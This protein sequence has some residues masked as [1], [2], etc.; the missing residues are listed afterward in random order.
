M[1]RAFARG[2]A[3]VLLALS[4]AATG[5]GPSTAL[6]AHHVPTEGLQPGLPVQLTRIKV[7]PSAPRPHEMLHVE[8]VAHALVPVDGTEM[9][10]RI[11]KAPLLSRDQLHVA[12]VD[13]ER[14]LDS[15]N[16]GPKMPVADI[17][18]GTDTPWSIDVPIDDLGLTF[19]V[20]Q[21]TVEYFDGD[22]V[23]RGRVNTFLPYFPAGDWLST[24]VAWVWPLVDA[25]RRSAVAQS[26]T[27]A[28]A[29]GRDAAAPPTPPGA[30]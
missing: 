7:L 6:A 19:G 13:T 11:S 23:P 29:P 9:R 3:A 18:P 30:P 22:F 2:A 27:P 4:S 16:V 14:P 26:S 8:G 10:L 21:L 5:L 17:V 12:A 25:P 20:Y 15:H 24:N 28:P 1:K